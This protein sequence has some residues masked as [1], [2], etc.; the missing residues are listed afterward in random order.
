MT[1]VKSFELKGN[2]LSFANWISNLSPTSTPFTSMI[3]KEAI[4]QTQYSWQTDSLAPASAETFEEG[5]QATLQPRASTNVFTNFTSLIRRAVRVSDTNESTRAYGRQDEM[6]YQM[7]MAGKAVLRDIEYMNLS[8]IRG[9]PGSADVSSTHSGFKELCAPL[10]IPD[11]DTFALTHQGVAVVD[12]DKP[13]F[14]LKDIFKVTTELF[15]AG[16]RAD[17]IM[18][19]PKHINIFS[20]QIGFNEEEPMIFRLFDNLDTKFNANVSKIKDPVGRVYTL[21]PN[22]WMPEGQV[23]IFS[24]KDWTQMVLQQPVRKTLAK[25]GSSTAVY[26]ETEVGLRH[27]HP[28]ASG[29]LDLIVVNF[30]TELIVDNEKMTA[31]IDEKTHLSF[32][33]EN[34]D[35]SAA[36]GVEAY[37]APSLD[38]GLAF[39]KTKF[40]TDATGFDVIEV[41]AREPHK[42]TL[43]AFMQE[44]GKVVMTNAVTVEVVPPNVEFS[45]SGK[46]QAFNHSTL[47]FKA[48]NAHGD[49]VPAGT[50]LYLSADE[51]LNIAG[52]GNDRVDLDSNGEGF[53]SLFPQVVGKI[54]FRA[55]FEE[56]E[57][58]W[59]TFPF[60]LDVEDNDFRL[61]FDKDTKT[62]LTRTLDTNPQDVHVTLFD[63]TAV[64]AGERVTFK[65]TNPEVVYFEDADYT[66]AVDGVASAKMH[67]KGIGEAQII[68][69]FQNKAKSLNIRVGDGSVVLTLS[70]SSIE[71]GEPGDI[72]ATAQIFEASGEP[73]RHGGVE[74]HWGSDPDNME[75]DF[76][77]AGPTPTNDQGIATNKI[78]PRGRVTKG[79]IEALWTEAGEFGKA[80]FEVTKTKFKASFEEKEVYLVGGLGEEYSIRAKVSHSWA[81]VNAHDL[82]FSTSNANA[83][84][85][86]SLVG[87]TDQTGYVHP[88]NKLL[89]D[90]FGKAI[91]TVKGTDTDVEECEPGVMTVHVVAPVVSFTSDNLRLLEGD[92]GTA[93]IT[94]E[95]PKGN[96]IENFRGSLGVVTDSNI[97]T[98]GSDTVTFADSKTTLNFSA[99]QRGSAEI[100][101]ILGTDVE[102]SVKGSNVVEVIQPD[103]RV[104][105]IP[106]EYT[107]GGTVDIKA[108]LSK[109]ATSTADLSGKTIRLTVNPDS[110][111]GV[112]SGTLGTTDANGTATFT[113]GAIQ[114]NSDYTITAS[115]NGVSSSCEL[116]EAQP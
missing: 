114:V 92:S 84:D 94:L 20:D 14:A 21:V 8:P 44:Q 78:E 13:W 65:S 56:R 37:L 98:L 38:V 83:A 42:T 111:P 85:W 93:T 50:T 6:A 82:K 35:G 27:K 5:S 47:H 87:H 45:A 89:A 80:P 31:F 104:T 76:E 36:Q 86:T 46:T 48:T 26:V 107:V 16:S 79:V 22:R 9:N 68:A 99:N 73:A 34:K 58:A 10:F 23:Y 75:F 24:E 95:D 57:G 74:I 51:G 60:E 105:T 81:D 88:D 4:D 28:Y 100:K 70:K 17:K 2:K 113:T 77:H 59:K 18:F 43:Y 66:T 101:F 69:S 67:M 64:M 112:P 40:T 52:P 91:V 108:I 15:L 19:H 97:I 110:L 106:D 30:K 103:L 62:V 90:E 115:Y 116:V 32:S 71:I 1:V 55:A 61:E 96:I 53:I 63:D 41:T 33:A 12:E 29:V 49:P 54:H 109:P 11:P 102:L 7:G 72:I 39:D 25:K 3:G